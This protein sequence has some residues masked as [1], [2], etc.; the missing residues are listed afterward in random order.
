MGTYRVIDL[1][2]GFPGREFSV[3][4]NTPERA[5]EIALCEKLI[6][7]G[8]PRLLMC[9]V[10]WQTDNGVCM[11]RLYRKAMRRRPTRQLL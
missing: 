3:E 5:G 8:S 9:R 6:R 11:T 2:S 4:A 10:Y 1:R 7:S